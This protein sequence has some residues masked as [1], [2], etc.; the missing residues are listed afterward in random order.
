MNR[1]EQ[2]Q[3]W[4]WDNGYAPSGMSHNTFVDGTDGKITRSALKKARAKGWRYSNTKGFYNVNPNIKAKQQNQ[5]QDQPQQTPVVTPPKTR[6]VPK[7]VDNNNNNFYIPPRIPASEI[8]LVGIPEAPP[9]VRL[10]YDINAWDPN[11]I[12]YTPSQTSG[13]T[14]IE[15]CAK[16]A[17]NDIRTFQKGTV[18][19]PIY[20]HAWTRLAQGDGPYLSGYDY[21]TRGMRNANDNTINYEAADSLTNHIKDYYLDVNNTY[22]VNLAYGNNYRD[23]PSKDEAITLGKGRTLGTHTGNLWFDYNDKQWKITHNVHN[24]IMTSTLMDVLDPKKRRKTKIALTAIKPIDRYAT[25]S[26]PLDLQ[27]AP[28]GSVTN[29]DT[30]HITKQY[31]IFDYYNYDPKLNSEYKIINFFK[32]P[33]YRTIEEDT[34]LK[35]FPNGAPFQHL[36][37]SINQDKPFKTTANVFSPL[38]VEALEHAE[39]AINTLATD[40]GVPLNEVQDIYTLLPGILWKESNGGYPLAAGGVEN[41]KYLNAH[42]NREGDASRH[43]WNRVYTRSGDLINGVVNT[44]GGEDV[45][46]PRFTSE[47]MG[48]V[49][50][51]NANP[52][53]NLPITFMGRENRRIIRDSGIFS[54]PNTLSKMVWHWKHL[55]KMFEDGNNLH[56]LYNW[57]G[58]GLSDLGR[59]LLLESHNQGLESGIKKSYDAYR[60]SG[61]IDYLNQYY[62][63]QAAVRRDNKDL[64]N[65]YAKTILDNVVSRLNHPYHQS[66][67]DSILGEVVVTSR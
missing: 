29:N 1:A 67:D 40:Y 51:K 15:D 24:K 53:L 3:Q 22:A 28:V 31:D 17:N 33:I 54:G 46:K 59:A 62:D 16:W 50:F 8:N 13:R 36:G 2:I 64:I 37:F 23:M 60:N 63:E 41:T 21:V 34:H 20:G 58:T 38:A 52:E 65:G 45:M 18:F 39:K 26:L 66:I 9:G 4:L 6:L 44:F 7:P 11:I 56:L 5:Q 14:N 12:H 48:S 10:H 55:K 47:G 30:P 49:K 27:F 57:Y 42:L 61:N 19:K 35:E 32:T 25:N 43:K